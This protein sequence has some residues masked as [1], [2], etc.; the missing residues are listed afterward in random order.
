[1]GS[2]SV[3]FVVH[4]VF[5]LEWWTSAGSQAERIRLGQYRMDMRQASSEG[6]KDQVVLKLRIISAVA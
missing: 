3:Q 1:M 6:A 2:M 5:F 4:L